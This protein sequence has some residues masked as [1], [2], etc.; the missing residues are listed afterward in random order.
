MKSIQPLY[1]K[2]LKRD[3]YCVSDKVQVSGTNFNVIFTIIY[4]VSTFANL[5]SDKIVLIKVQLYVIGTVYLGYTLFCMHTYRA[6]R[7][8]CFYCKFT[9]VQNIISLWVMTHWYMDD[10]PKLFC[11]IFVGIIILSIIARGFI[12]KERAKKLMK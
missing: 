2:S 5:L 1:N 6:R 3:F 9:L 4:G 7:E 12:R 10:F 8:M 11:I